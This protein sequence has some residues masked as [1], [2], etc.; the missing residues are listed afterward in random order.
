M[1]DIE[2]AYNA[3]SAKARPYTQLFDYYDGD[4]PLMYASRRLDEIFAGLDT[5]FVENWCA[6]VID[7]LKDRVN[8]TAV[9]VDN[10]T[11]SAFVDDNQM[12][13]DSDDVHAAA[14]ICG[15]GFYVVWPDEDGK[16]EGYHN[17]P[18]L[19]HV[20]YQAEKPRQPEFAAKWW[21]GEKDNLRYMTLYYTDRLE[22]YVSTKQYDKITNAKSLRLI[23]EAPNKY[24][25]I[26]IF[27]FRPASRKITSDIKNAIPLQN[28]INKL[29]TDMM[30]AAEYGAFKQRVVITDADIAGKLKNAPGEIWKVPAGDGVGQGT[31]VTEFDAT[32]LTNYLGAI[33]NLSQAIA[34][35]TRTPRHYFMSMGGDPSGE[36][37]ITMESPLAKKAQDR[38]DR[39]VPVWQQVLAFVAKINGETVEPDDIIVQF[40]RPETVQPR[41]QAEI[42]EA[43]MRSG[44]PLEI[45]LRD[46]GKTDAEI[47]VVMEAK[48]REAAEAKTA[49]SQ[50]L[51]DSRRGFDSGGVA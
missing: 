38:I 11:I 29:L 34:T 18:R 43:N 9:N 36:A 44:I 3:L 49:F 30:V 16:A 39:F 8:M 12:I 21:V 40:D 51:L 10:R 13:M 1:T 41:T 17:D 26:P 35:I 33:D 37:L 15:E 42:R 48:R 6:V 7:S 50:A 31:S 28:G 32:D 45:T 46:E 23:D 4:Q 22:Y 20:F 27:H 47:E 14:M 5:V 25:Q 19:C 2:R 24:G